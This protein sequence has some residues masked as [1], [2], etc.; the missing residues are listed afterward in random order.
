VPTVEMTWAPTATA[1]PKRGAADDRTTNVIIGASES[2]ST[3]VIAARQ[4]R[5]VCGCAVLCCVRVCVCVCGRSSP[6]SRGCHSRDRRRRDD[7][8]N[9]ACSAAKHLWVQSDDDVVVSRWVER[10]SL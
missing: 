8:A 6:A 5:G 10:V 7:S 4:A 1:S 3:S 9:Q 2:T